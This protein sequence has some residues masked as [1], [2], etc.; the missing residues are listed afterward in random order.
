MRPKMGMMSK[1][2]AM[3][4][5][6][7]LSLRESAHEENVH[8][9]L[10]SDAE[11]AEIIQRV[12]TM[13][14]SH[15][16]PK[17]VSYRHAGDYRSAYLGRGLD[18]EEVR[19]YQRGDDVRGMDW[20]TTARIGKP[21]V[22][23]YR[24]EHQPALHIVMDRSTSMR[25]G[26]RKQLKVTLAARLA[27]IFA[28]GAMSSNAC[29]GGTIWQSGGFTLP[30]RNGEEG[31]IRLVR[32]AISPCPPMTEFSPHK[33][34]DTFDALLRQLDSLLPRGSRL[35]LISDFGQL[36]EQDLPLLLRLNSHHE[37]V[38]LQV[39]D[40]AEGMLTDVGSM[41][42]Q[43]LASGG[44]RWLDTGSHVVRDT[45]RKN[46]VALHNNQRAMF[47]RIGVR[48]YSCTT[49]EDPFGLYAKVTG[50]E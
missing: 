24:E 33:G 23:I 16:Q 39:L 12:R 7:M 10:L 43:D 15:H 17:E 2:F 34:M 45:F 6:R 11:L 46:A 37:L 40:V 20:R 30:C 36:H 27:A 5:R 28:F 42:F 35:V 25:F 31:A 49:D 9:P 21:Y 8:A 1:N 18:F 41:P 26:T 29:I 13:D 50:H 48:L 19:P 22:K 32:A 47:Q 44:V 38:A 4:L 3:H 14:L